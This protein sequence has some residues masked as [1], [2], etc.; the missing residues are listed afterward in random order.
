MQPDL[1]P[2]PLPLLLSRITSHT[3]GP[4]PF[5]EELAAGARSELAGCKRDV[6]ELKLE[7]D[8]LDRAK[9][10]LAAADH[11]KAVQ[12]RLDGCTKLYRQAVV[13]SKRQ[14]DTFSHLSA[15]DE[16]LSAQ[17]GQYGAGGGRDSP[18]PYARGG[19][20]RAK[21]PQ[22]GQSGD[23]ALMSAT[24]DV[25]EGLRRTLQ[26]MQQEVDRSL[27]SNEL[28][29][30]QTQTM[31][32]TSDEY[33]TLSSLMSTSKNLIT[34]LERADI[35]D[36]LLLFGAFAFFA[37]VCAHIFKKRVLDRGVK[38]AGALGRVVTRSG[39]VLAGAAKH[40]GA[41]AGGGGGVGEHVQQAK[42]EG[43]ARVLTSEIVGEITQAAATATAVVGAIKAGVTSLA[44]GTRA[45][46]KEEPAE[47]AAPF[48]EV[49]PVRGERRAA[50][51][52]LE[53]QQQEEEDV[54][55]EPYDDAQQ[56]PLYADE[57]ESGASSTTKEEEPPL[58]IPA[59]PFDSLT[60]DAY[61]S[62]SAAPLIAESTHFDDAVPS[63]T[64]TFIESP[65]TAS[66]PP[67]PVEPVSQ[68]PLEDIPAPQEGQGLLERGDAD[69]HQVPPLPSDA[70][71]VKEAQESPSPTDPS[72]SSSAPV[73][74]VERDEPTF[75]PASEYAPPPR[76]VEEDIDRFETDNGEPEAQAE[77]DLPSRPDEI[78]EL[79]AATP[80]LPD[81]EELAGETPA[82]LP[83]HKPDLQNLVAEE[84]ASFDGEEDKTATGTSSEALHETV[85]DT[86]EKIFTPLP[87]LRRTRPDLDEQL[88]DIN[89]IVAENA[90]PPPTCSEPLDDEPVEVAPSKI[91]LPAS[92][93]NATTLPES[94]A[95]PSPSSTE[96]DYDD[97][98]PLLSDPYSDEPAAAPV[99]AD[100]PSL[101]PLNPAFIISHSHSA[102]LPREIAGP[103]GTTVPLVPGE[104]DK[105]TVPPL[106]VEGTGQ[107]PLAEEGQVELP[108]DLEKEQTIWEEAPASVMEAEQVAG[109]EGVAVETA[110]EAKVEEDG[111]GDE[112]LLERMM[113]QQFRG[114]AGTV[115]GA[116]VNATE[117][118]VAPSADAEQEDGQ[119]QGRQEEA[120]AAQVEKSIEATEAAHSS[121]AEDNESDA[122]GARQL[123]VE[124]EEPSF[125]T[126]PTPPSPSTTT[127]FTPHTSTHFIE[128]VLSTDG[129]FAAS[130]PLPTPEPA[131]AAAEAT[132]AVPPASDSDN[133]PFVTSSSP[134]VEVTTAEA[135]VTTP[136]ESPI[137]STET[138]AS[139]S[140]PELEPSTFA[141]T[142]ED[143]QPATTDAVLTSQ[144]EEP[145]ETAVSHSAAS[146]ADAGASQES[147]GEGAF[148]PT[149]ILTGAAVPAGEATPTPDP[150][151]VPSLDASA[152]KPTSSLASSSSAA[153][154]TPSAT[155]DDLAHDLANSDLLYPDSSVEDSPTLVEQVSVGEEDFD[156]SSE[157]LFDA[158]AD[159]AVSQHVG[160]D[161]EPLEGHGVDER[162]HRAEERLQELEEEEGREEEF[163]VDAGREH[164]RD[165][166]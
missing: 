115:G 83:P 132:I 110:E 107:V 136:A 133:L 72:P 33:S 163:Q 81:I 21:S 131:P 143:E 100:D 156:G 159:E 127:S 164:A 41:A 152:N 89:S 111:K 106:D 116:V 70:E 142:T 126:E 4:L 57:L 59:E 82:V 84:A 45:Q 47:A 101:D 135:T 153:D 137:D 96:V 50:P 80:I 10:R 58:P 157:G 7:V 160:E 44:R 128:D 150:A 146:E 134:E 91:D 122:E 92:S 139:S 49:V 29:Q 78:E 125:D 149:S 75:P 97:A 9:D 161:E 1:D 88:G 15:R 60:D 166:L 35:I 64:S 112:D 46:E 113:E 62:S 158:T 77:T 39:G 144:A 148:S 30:S 12:Q 102:D 86:E 13:T 66:P 90:I 118:L 79:V 71:P 147:P 93:D 16:L 27:V 51:V 6:E 67:S 2:L 17:S 162:L 85:I 23:D 120:P 38:V 68:L 36:R 138:H 69:L 129:D 61:I 94:T 52:E 108:I 3:S 14:I 109:D 140:T 28:L 8:D 22:P 119:H 76:Q 74:D 95:M 25:T 32:L 42:Q 63:A 53:Q 154:A 98:T 130:P 54:A 55:E 105:E 37:A 24:S 87:S 114:V 145:V 5:H 73:V 18:G 56:E 26:L 121:V 43:A 48:E 40:V 65:S 99:L 104:V 141:T 19:L 165:E 31:Q 103:E 117:A 34:S 124:Q 151:S 20:N 123:E 11:V 155:P